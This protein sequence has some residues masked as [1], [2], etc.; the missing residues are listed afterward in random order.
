MYIA[1]IPIVLFVM[2]DS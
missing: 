2:M 1:L